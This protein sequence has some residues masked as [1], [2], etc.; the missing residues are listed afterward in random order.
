MVFDVSDRSRCF[1]DGSHVGSYPFLLAD[2]PFCRGV[3]K[4]CLFLCSCVRSVDGELSLICSIVVYVNR[5][6]D[7]VCMAKK[8]FS[9]EKFVGGGNCEVQYF[10]RAVVPSL[11]DSRT[12]V[13]SRLQG[14]VL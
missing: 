3:L 13:Q 2:L 5:W 7:V 4:T 10:R 9:R 6:V 11:S 14:T 8:H 12:R 1:H